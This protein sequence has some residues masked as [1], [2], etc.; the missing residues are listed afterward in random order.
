[1]EDLVDLAGPVI[2]VRE[3]VETFRAHGVVL[4]GWQETASGVV[5]AIAAWRTGHPTA[6]PN[7]LALRRDTP[8]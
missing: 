8:A 4:D 5:A 3:L 6:P 1:M 2:E 7:D